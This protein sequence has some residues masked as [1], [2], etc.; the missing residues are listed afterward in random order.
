M[1]GDGCE[2]REKPEEA[3]RLAE[4]SLI[5]AELVTT[6]FLWCETRPQVFPPRRTAT[7]ECE[8]S[9]IIKLK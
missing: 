2:E 7:G 6:M 8:E 5:E 4:S 3:C 9:F 1:T